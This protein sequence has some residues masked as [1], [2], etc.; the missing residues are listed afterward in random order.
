MFEIANLLLQLPEWKLAEDRASIL[1][2]FRARNYVHA[3]AILNEVAIVAE[4]EGHHPNHSLTKYSRLSFQLTT[5][6]AKGLTMNDFVMAKL[7]EE[8]LLRR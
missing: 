4:Q 5:F 3:M 8:V 2:E 7:I 6:A 1:R